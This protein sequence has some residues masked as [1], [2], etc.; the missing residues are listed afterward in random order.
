MQTFPTE[1][2]LEL[3]FSAQ[4]LNGGYKVHT[5]RFSEGRPALYSNKE[6][7]TYSAYYYFDN[8]PES[9]KMWIPSDFEPLK[10]TDKDR[11]AKDAADCHMRRY[12]M[13]A[14]GK[15]SMFESDIFTAYSSEYVPLNQ[16]GLIAY[17]PEFVDREIQEKI[18]LTRLKEDFAD[19]KHIKH[20]RIE[21]AKVEILKKIPLRE[22]DTNLYFAA[23]GND[24]VSFSKSYDYDIGDVFEIRARVKDLCVER[25]T[26]L[27][28]SRLN[29]VKLKKV[30]K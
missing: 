16:I 20:I 24:L 27:P 12:S 23:I 19:S 8:S 14:L 5:Q 6:L 7:V 10:V 25:K 17:I 13:L 22:Y 3:A 18:Y 2:V 11:S 4:R 9:T 30:K 28:M 26:N 29:Y 15:I 21:G 1:R